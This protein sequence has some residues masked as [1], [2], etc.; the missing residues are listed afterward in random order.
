MINQKVV[1]R[2][3]E[4]VGLSTC[5][6]YNIKYTV[7]MNEWMIM[8]SPKGNQSGFPGSLQKYGEMCIIFIF[9][10]FLQIKAD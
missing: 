4:L 8:K 2:F 1:I 6:E 7:G 5:S 3:L 9:V 10:F